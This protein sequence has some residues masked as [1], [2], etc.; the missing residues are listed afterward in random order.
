M[1]SSYTLPGID[2]RCHQQTKDC[3]V[4]NANPLACMSQWDWAAALRQ[5]LRSIAWEM[6]NDGMGSPLHSPAG[7]ARCQVFS[8]LKSEGRR[9]NT[10]NRCHIPTIAVLHVP[11]SP[12]REQIGGSW[13]LAAHR[14]L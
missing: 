10:V 4:G 5:V 7:V 2:A 11:C 14:L 6:Q 12:K 8:K 9:R 13:R 1:L 3:Q